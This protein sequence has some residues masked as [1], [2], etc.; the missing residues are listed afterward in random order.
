MK[1]LSCI[2]M[3]TYNFLLA[4]QNI[5]LLEDICKQLAISS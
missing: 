3:W 1:N 5:K 2:C 4:M